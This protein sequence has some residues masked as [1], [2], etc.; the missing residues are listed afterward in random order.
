MR[1]ILAYL[2]L[3]SFFSTSAFADPA[4]LTANVNFRTGPGTGFQAMSVVKK[5][6]EVDIKECDGR[7]EWCAV[8]YSGLNGFAAGKYLTQTGT[9]TSA[10]PK[11][12]TTE[13]GAAITLFQ[14]Q[15]TEWTDLARLEALIATE[16]QV[17]KDARPAYG[18]IGVS[19]RTIAD[20][21]TGDVTLTDLKS[22][23]I[24][25]STL[26]RKQLSDLSLEVGKL[27]PTDP[28]AVSEERLTASLANYK[29]LSNIADIKADPPPIFISETPAVLL[30]TNGVA[31]SAPVKGVQGLSFVVNTNW[32]LLKVDATNTLY[33]RSD[34][35]WLT[36]NALDSGWAEAKTVPDLLSNLPDD[37]NWKDAKTALPPAPF[38][39]GAT[40]K[41]FFSDKPAE[42]IVFEGK[43]TLESVP[44]TGLDWVSN[45]TGAVFYH[46]ALKVWYTLLSGRWF[47]SS[48]LGG[49]WTFATTHLPKDFLNIPEDAPYAAVRA[50]IPGTS[51]SA[52]ARL[53][54]SIPKMARVATDGSVNVEV[55]YGGEPKFEPI[56][57]TSMFYAVNA[58]EQVIKVAEKY[59]VLK[60][61]I[62]FVGDTPVGPFSVAR[63]VDEQI[64]DIPPSSPVYN[65]TY[66]HIYETE[67]DAIWF[68]YTL[69]YLGMNCPPFRPDS[70]HKQKGSSTGLRTGL[71]LTSI[72]TL[73]C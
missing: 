63:A 44:G 28:I 70:R 41:V 30:Q 40:P 2:M 21:A 27:L 51:E 18:I 47:S 49:P 26:E 15:I 33:L 8:S 60:D 69:G 46:R 19:A 65:A 43:P 38:A 16:L 10:W 5:G 6:E 24:E 50:S 55:V 14:P 36:S 7:A 58:S 45:T 68:G 54:A 34:K 25:F 67:D 56:E 59:Y 12:F 1:K 57:G 13:S 62:W 17:S 64:Y 29:R 9:T 39:E 22:T 32:D 61:G 52:E 31:V 11:V 20:D 23:R 35:N 71:C 42:L 72:D 73:N 37:D 48:L 66:V 3:A 4:I 53:K